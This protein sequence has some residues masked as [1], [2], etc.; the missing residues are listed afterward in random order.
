MGHGGSDMGG[1][2]GWSEE[3]YVED[4][5]SS[6]CLS[7]SLPEAAALSVT[8]DG[9]AFA[10]SFIDMRDVSVAPL[11]DADGLDEG[12]AALR[13]EAMSLCGRMH[14]PAVAAAMR[15]LSAAARA[16]IP[17][18]GALAP[19]DVAHGATMHVSLAS[20]SYGD[21]LVDGP[22]DPFECVVASL[23]AGDGRTEPS[24]AGRRAAGVHVALDM[25]ADDL[26]GDGPGG[27]L[28]FVSVGGT[29]DGSLLVRSLSVDGCS[30]DAAE[31]LG[32]AAGAS[33]AAQVLGAVIDRADDRPEAPAAAR[34]GEGR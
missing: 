11:P 25:Y 34:V 14:A 17:L 5:G 1:A 23:W 31:A 15:M 32:T 10:E 6:R 28:M 24:G 30:L 9:G 33:F 13:S 27:S 20:D 26:P 3:D 18:L 22:D 16:A 8:S 4:D 19:G 21:P 29:I 7:M 2:S 12:V